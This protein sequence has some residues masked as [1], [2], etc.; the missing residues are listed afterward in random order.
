MLAP[1]GMF[2]DL[3]LK[4]VG[5]VDGH[6]IAAVE[7]ALRQAKQFGGPVLVHCLTRKGNGFKA[8]E[9]H[10]EDRFHAVGK[11]DAGTGGR[12]AAAGGQ[13]WTDVFAE[14]MV[15]L[16]AARPAGR[17]HHRRHDLPD[18]SAPLRRGLPRPLLRR[19]HRRAA[20]RHLRRRHGDGRAA[21]G[22]RASTRPSSTG[23]STSC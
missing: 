13:T 18:R 22:G 10:E 2:A 16:G 3:G 12:S 4:Y 9:D 1:Q 23:P 7:R 21:P 19:R 15:R 14:E 11:I 6:D 17:G 8:A 20:R 5:P